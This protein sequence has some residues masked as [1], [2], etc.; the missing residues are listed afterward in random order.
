MTRPL[1]WLEISADYR[2][3]NQCLGCFSVCDS[4]DPSSPMAARMD[5][6][7]A[8]LA[9]QQG[10]QQGIDQLWLGGGEPTLRSDLLRLVVAA[11]KLGYRTVKLQTNA[12]RLAYRDYVAR[13]QRAGLD[14]VNVSIKSHVA[15]EHDRLTRTPGCHELMVQAIEHC[16]DLGLDLTGDVLVYRSTVEQLPELIDWYRQRGIARFNLWLLSKAAQGEESSVAAEVPRLSDVTAQIQRALASQSNPPPDLITSL[17]TP[18]CTLPAG[19]EAARFFPRELDLLVLNP[20]GHSFR[21][22]ESP[23]EGGWFAPQC[24]RCSLR[25]R[26]GG[27]RQEYVEQFGSDEITPLGGD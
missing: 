1:R 19:C 22:E 15:P 3:N 2:C 26:C 23:I 27:L 5:T 7:E 25:N 4:D 20:G 17:H 21:L 18:A 24:E 12:M 10:R 8:V 14:Q 6:R 13:L 9:L 16:R 11:K